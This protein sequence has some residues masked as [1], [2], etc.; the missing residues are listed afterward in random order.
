[1]EKPELSTATLE[2]LLEYA[3]IL[4]NEDGTFGREIEVLKVILDRFPNYQSSRFMGTTDQ[5]ISLLETTITWQ[6]R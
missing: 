4:D 5:L 6:R 3:G 2:E 1:M